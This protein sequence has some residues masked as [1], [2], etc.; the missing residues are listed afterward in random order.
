MSTRKQKVG[1][2]L[3]SLIMTQK[4]IEQTFFSG[5]RGLGEQQTISMRPNYN[6][7]KKIAKYSRERREYL[8]RHGMRR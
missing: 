3:L 4:M 8:A 7:A 6:C 2:I 1:A 5:G